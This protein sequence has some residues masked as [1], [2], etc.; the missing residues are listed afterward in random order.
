MFLLSYVCSCRQHVFIRL[1]LNVPLSK[2]DGKTITSDKRLRAVVPTL[3]FLK[4]QGAKI[5]IATHIGRPKEQP[6]PDSFKTNVVTK[7]C[8]AEVRP[9]PT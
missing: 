3:K 1:D 5:V 8:A 6:F 4:D 7:R 2:E 9:V